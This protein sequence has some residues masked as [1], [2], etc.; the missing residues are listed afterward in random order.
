[1]FGKKKFGVS[2]FAGESKAGAAPPPKKEEASG[3]ALWWFYAYLC[4]KKPSLAWAALPTAPAEFV[5]S[6]PER[7]RLEDNE[8]VL[9]PAPRSLGNQERQDREDLDTI[10]TILELMPPDATG[11]ELL[12]AGKVRFKFP[13]TPQPRPRLAAMRAKLKAERWDITAA[14]KE[15]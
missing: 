15:E 12:P 1:M 7:P 2:V 5:P 14:T 13:P 6:C 3:P 11:F 9:A 4:K 10:I 8:P